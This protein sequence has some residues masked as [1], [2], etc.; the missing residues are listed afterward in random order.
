MIAMC[1]FTYFIILMESWI[2]FRPSFSRAGK[3]E[4]NFSFAMIVLAGFVPWFLIFFGTGQS[5]KR[6]STHFLLA[7]IIY[8]KL[9]G[10]G[11]SFPFIF[12]LAVS[13]FTRQH[14]F[15]H[16][17]G[18]LC[19]RL[20]GTKTVSDFSILKGQISSIVF[21]PQ[22]PS[23]SLCSQRPNLNP[24]LYIS[25]QGRKVSEIQA[26]ELSLTQSRTCFVLSLGG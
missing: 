8:F 11:D 13:V 18:T 25:F 21:R 23:T 7:I 4:D 24:E 6:H 1:V 20:L 22:Q 3:V 5:L 15:K 2:S 26:F 9:R 14:C 19:S 16:W 10:Y 17:Y 12:P